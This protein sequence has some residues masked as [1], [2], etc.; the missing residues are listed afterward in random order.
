[1]PT[2]KEIASMRKYFDKNHNKIYL[3]SQD[4]LLTNLIE[5]CKNHTL[6]QL[7]LS[8]IIEFQEA[9]RTKFKSDLK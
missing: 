1:M 3:K 2:K 4:D 8:T 5:L 6:D 7:P 9:L